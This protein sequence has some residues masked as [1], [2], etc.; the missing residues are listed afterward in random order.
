MLRVS[1]LH[2]KTC[3]PRI[4]IAFRTML[5]YMKSIMLLKTLWLLKIVLVLISRTPIAFPC[6]IRDKASPSL[7][8]LR[9]IMR[10]KLYNL[11][12]WQPL[13]SDLDQTVT[14]AKTT[15]SSVV[16]E[17][18]LAKVT[19]LLDKPVSYLLHQAITLL[20]TIRALLVT[21]IEALILRQRAALC[22]TDTQIKCLLYN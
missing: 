18:E 21:V 14:C 7:T 16:I 12:E 19:D 1:D 10:S 22:S 3:H 17:K 9:M 5:C 8:W 13:S 6:W 11:T 2:S 15:N 20:T 4:L